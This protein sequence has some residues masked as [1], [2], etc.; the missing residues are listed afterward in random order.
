MR[1]NGLIPNVSMARLLPLLVCVLTAVVHS[2]PAPTDRRSGRDPH[3]PTPLEIMG[4]GF[5]GALNEF[6]A[7]CVTSCK[8]PT[9]IVP[10]NPPTEVTLHSCGHYPQPLL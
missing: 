5:N 9:A 2:V 10:G 1:S 4:G 6:C 7:G 8:D 3:K